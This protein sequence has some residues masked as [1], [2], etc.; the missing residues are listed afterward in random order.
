MIM[1]GCA[2]YPWTG[3]AAIP[4]LQYA[5]LVNPLVYVSEGLRA[6]LTPRLPHMSLAAVIGALAVITLLLWA[7]GVRTF[8]GRA[9]S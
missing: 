4:W 8:K 7:A 1:F 2:Y 5:V 6:A 3:L 9:F